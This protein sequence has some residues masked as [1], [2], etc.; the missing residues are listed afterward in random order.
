MITLFIH[1]VADSAVLG[2]LQNIL[3]RRQIAMIA[4]AATLATVIIPPYIEENMP[5]KASAMEVIAPSMP[6]S[7][8]NAIDIVLNTAIIADIADQSV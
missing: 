7:S 2:F 6:C 8:A 3:I 5:L 4:A 1:S